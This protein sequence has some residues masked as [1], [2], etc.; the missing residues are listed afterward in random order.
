MNKVILAVAIILFASCS[1][2]TRTT[3]NKGTSTDSIANQAV[4]PLEQTPIYAKLQIMPNTKAGDS[5]ILKFTVYNDADT[6]QQFCKWH[7][8]FE[9]LMSKYLDVTSDTGEEVAY[10]GPMAKRIMPPPADSYMK[11]NPKDSLSINVN[12]LK[13]YDLNKPGKYIIKYNAT[14][15]SGI[16]AKDSI[17][18]T[19]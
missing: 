18:F 5:V 7:T 9:P 11:L 6:V 3:E 19:L 8:P 1:Q 15:I 12:L 2:N 10:K 16:V 13:A 17:S 14:N 4:K